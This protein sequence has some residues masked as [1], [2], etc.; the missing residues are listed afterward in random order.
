MDLTQGLQRLLLPIKNKIF[1]IIGR[2]IVTLIDNS[3]TKFQ[4]VQLN[5]LA[6][7]TISDIERV[8]PY[9]LETYPWSMSPNS[10]S[11]L[12]KGTDPNNLAEVQAIAAFLNGNRDQGL[13]IVVGDRYYRLTDLAQGEVALYTFKDKEAAGHRIHLKAD[14]SIEVKGTSIDITVTG[15]CNITC[16]TANITATTAINLDGGSGSC[17]GVITGASICHFTGAPHADISSNVKSS[18]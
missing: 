12:F 2:G 15:E 8:Q 13:I 9:G 5:A 14:G 10:T 3:G 16:S 6:D 18:K 7:E 1:N 11:K 17:L 4:K